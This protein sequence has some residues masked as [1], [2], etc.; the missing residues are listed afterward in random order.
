MSLDS[1]CKHSNALQAEVTVHLKVE[2]FLAMTYGGNLRMGVSGSD[3]YIEMREVKDGA[4]LVH[5]EMRGHK[6]WLNL[7]HG[8]ESTEQEMDDWGFGADTV[9]GHVPPRG[10]AMVF[11]KEGVKMI[12][13]HTNGS[14]WNELL[15]PY[16]EDM[17]FFGGNYYG[18]WS[19]DNDGKV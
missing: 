11:C 2:H 6:L 3:P 12:T 17:L 13:Y 7:W 14:G 15:V 10:D 18:D 4:I 16:V 5:P 9:E 19:A 1:Y 8:R